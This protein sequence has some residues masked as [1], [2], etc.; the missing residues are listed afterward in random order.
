[1]VRVLV[2]GGRQFEDRD[3][4]NAAL[5][6]L[7]H[8]RGFSLVI[9]GGAPGADSLAEAWAKA[10]GV[11]RKIYA[12]RWEYPGTRNQRMLDGAGRTSSWRSQEATEL[13]TWSVAPGPL[14]SRSSILER[15]S[16]GDPHRAVMCGNR[17]RRQPRKRAAP[18]WTLHCDIATVP[19]LA[20]PRALPQHV[21]GGVRTPPNDGRRQRHRRVTQTRPARAVQPYPALELAEFAERGRC[22]MGCAA[23]LHQGKRRSEDVKPRGMVAEDGATTRS[24]WRGQSQVGASGDFYLPLRLL[25]GSH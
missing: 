8:E 22:M 21:A 10:A 12:P 4:L 14:V 17:K 15:R 2:C 11:P 9:S 6:K 3:M 24:S 18:A 13:L 25:P 1:M 20:A 19:A 5:D 7:H 16:P 23:H